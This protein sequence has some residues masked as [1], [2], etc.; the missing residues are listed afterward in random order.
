MSILYENDVSPAPLAHRTVALLGYGNQGRPQALNLRDSGINVI[1]GLRANSLYTEQA[2][3][4]GFSVY[5]MKEACRQADVVMVLLPD[6]VMAQAYQEHMADQLRPGTY[7]GFGHGLAIHAGWIQPRADL[8][9]FLVAPKAQGRGVRNKFVAGSG[10]PTLVG[11]HQDPSGETQGVA[12]AYARALGAGRIGIFPTTFQEETECDLFTEQVVL[13]GGLS[14]LI[15]A[16][17]DTLI[18]RG[19]SPDTAYFE[20]LYEVKLIGDL[21]HERGIHGMRQG[22]SS[23]ALFGDISRGER[24]IDGHVR[25]TMRQVL[26]EI[27]SGRFAQEMRAEFE[28]GKPRITAKMAQDYHHPLEETHRRLAD[29][30]HR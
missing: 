2:Q 13:C 11:V 9:V 6:E 25:E 8:N 5:S 23:T 1:V 17:Y 7:L 26:S 12:L 22:I 28:Q 21:L 20:C 27:T 3:A 19:Y 15:K 4:D 30:L 29:N 18:E 14:A 10:V 16:A 24:I